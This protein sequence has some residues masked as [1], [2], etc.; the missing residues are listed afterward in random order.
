MDVIF[1]RVALSFMVDR[2]LN[3]SRPVDFID[4]PR[5]ADAGSDVEEHF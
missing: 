5:L 4:W 1:I 3:P 2:L